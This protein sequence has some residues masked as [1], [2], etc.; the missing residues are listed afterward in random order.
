MKKIILAIA[1]FGMISLT[2]CK[3]NSSEKIESE[4]DQALVDAR[5][6]AVE[7]KEETGDIKSAE[8]AAMEVPEFSDPEV[9]K[10]ANEYAKYFEDLLKASRSGNMEKAEELTRQ[11]IEWTKRAS[12][13]TQKMSSEDSQKWTEWT[14]KLRDLVNE[15]N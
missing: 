10:F 6:Q 4:A 5:E 13:L 1:V 7:L 12:E 2:S 15:G 8:Q 14:N 11:G 3:N 9:Q